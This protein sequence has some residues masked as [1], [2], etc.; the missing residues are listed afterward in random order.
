[1]A[2]TVSGTVTISGSPAPDASNVVKIW[3]D[4]GAGD[5]DLIDTVDITGGA[6][7]F[8][9]TVPDAV[10]DYFAVYDNGT[11]RGASALGTPTGT[12]PWTVDATSGWAFPA[13]ATEW[14]D[15]I[16]SNGALSAWS[17][18]DSLHLFQEA[19]GTLADAI[20]SITWG[21]AGS[22]QDY[23]VTDAALTR[24]CARSRGDEW[25][26]TSASLPDASG[27]SYLMLAVCKHETAALS[28]KVFLGAS[29]PTT[30]QTLAGGE[31]RLIAGATTDG[32]TNQAGVWMPQVVQLNR[33]T[34]TSL[35]ASLDTKVTAAMGA[36]S[37]KQEFVN[38]GLVGSGSTLYAYAAVWRGVPAE[39]TAAQIKALQQAL[40]FTITW[41]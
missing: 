13:T 22:R 40:G 33:A 11:Y 18:P 30:L 2:Y 7:S 14:T 36:V 9:C 25:F 38:G 31:F 3:A 15:F 5:G 4:D 35:A 27:S 23:Q 26:S 32:A 1:M 37:G 34:T 28:T 39:R 29:T 19:S 17:A 16:A 8:T 10:R 41:T 20:G 6:G 12:A 24:K 21:S